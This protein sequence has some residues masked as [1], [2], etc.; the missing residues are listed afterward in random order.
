MLEKP[1]RFGS[2]KPIIRVRQLPPT[3]HL[4]AQIIEDRRGFVLLRRRREANS[5]IENECS[6]SR[7][8]LPLA[9]LGN[10]RDVLRH[11][12]GFSRLLRDRKST[13]LNS[14]HLGI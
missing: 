1:H 13:R 11:A 7:E 5:L 9:R 10:R 12:P 8:L 3:V 2:A 6:L 4:I 14:S